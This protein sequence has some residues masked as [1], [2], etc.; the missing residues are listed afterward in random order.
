LVICLPVYND[1]WWFSMYPKR[2]FALLIIW[3][4]RKRAFE[5]AF[6]KSW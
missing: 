3:I 1:E 2:Q 4:S 5:V 6:S